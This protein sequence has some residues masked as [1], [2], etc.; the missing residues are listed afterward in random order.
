MK[1]V[2]EIEGQLLTNSQDVRAVLEVLNLIELSDQYPSLIVQTSEGAYTQVYGVR[3]TTPLN[4]DEA[5]E[6]Y[7]QLSQPELRKEQTR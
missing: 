1:L 6:L 2:K 3:Y 7:P 5:E 4:S